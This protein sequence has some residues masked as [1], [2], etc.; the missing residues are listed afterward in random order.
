V[1]RRA[2]G[3]LLLL[4]AVLI[5]P[6]GGPPI[7]V[8]GPSPADDLTC[9]V[10]SPPAIPA[11]LATAATS[12]AGT[13]PGSFAVSTG[14]SATYA[15]P[16]VV[17]PGRLGLEPRLS[18]TY[19][20]AAG[21]GPLGV[22]FAL[23]GVSAITRC[24]S[25]LA[26]DG[27]I[28]AVEYDEQ[29]KLC[30]GNLRLVPARVTATTVE[31][32]TFP[33]TFSKIVADYSAG[34]SLGP[35]SFEV[36]AKDGHVFEYGAGPNSR[37]MATGGVVAAWWL[38][39]EQDRRGNAV[40]YTYENDADPDDA[41]TIEIVPSR[42]DYTRHDPTPASR[43]VVLEYAGTVRGLTTSTLYSGGLTFIRSKLLQAIRM[44][45]EP[46]GSVV[47]SYVFAYAPGASTGRNL[48]QSVEECAGDSGP[49]K[50]ATR[51]SWSSRA[52]ALK[53]LVTPVMVPAAQ[54]DVKQLPGRYGSWVL[55]DV[56]G[57][58]LDD[59]VMGI[60]NATNPGLDDWSVALNTGGGFAPP[61]IW[62]T[63]PHPV[64]QGTG[65]TCGDDTCEDAWKLTPVDLDQDGL[66]DIFLDTANPEAS[67]WPHYRWLRALPDHRFELMDTDIA[68]PDGTDFS[69]DDAAVVPNK[70]Y[71][72]RFTR[73]GDVNGDG[74][75][76]LI[77]CVNPTWVGEGSSRTGG[78]PQW[79]VNLWVP[80]VPGTGGPGFDPTP[81][82]LPG[83]EELDCSAGLKNV[84]V[85]DIDGA[86]GSE[87]VISQNDG[88][89]GALRFQ[90]GGWTKIEPN[91]PVQPSWRTIH[92]LDVNGD[93]LSDAVYTGMGTVCGPWNGSWCSP[94]SPYTIDG[95]PD[96]VPFQ[97][98]NN[99]KT[100]SSPAGMLFSAPG[101]A[102]TSPLD[103]Y[104]DSA[105]ALDANGDG[106]MDLMMPVHGICGD[107]TDAACW[108]IMQSSATVQGNFGPNPPTPAIKDASYA[109]I[110]ETH[111]PFVADDGG[112][113]PWFQPQI[114]DV[115]GDGRHD[116]VMPNATGD[117]TFVIYQNTGPQDLLTAVTD[118]MSPLDPGD[119]GFVATISIEYGS[120]VD[121]TITLG[122]AQGSVARAN[123][124]YVSRYDSANG[125]DYPR[126]CVV[127]PQ[128]VVS[129]YH[130][131][132]GNNQ[133]R[134]FSLLY[135]DA[136]YHRL[137]R[138]DLGF[139]ERVVVD[140]DTGG[141]SAQIFDNVT[142]DPVLSTFP[143]AGHVVRSWSWA[144]AATPQ[145]T[146]TQIE[147]TYGLT[148]LQEVPADAGTYFI[149]SVLAQETRE[150]GVFQASPSTSLLQYV[151]ATEVNAALVLGHAH[152]TVSNY[153]NY[154][155]VL[156]HSSYAEG[157]DLHNTET[158][159]VSNDPVSW[160]IGLV[161]SDETCSTALGI[162][163]CRST[164]LEYNGYGEVTGKQIGDPAD[165]GTQLS[166][167]YL[168]DAWGNVWWT[169][170]DDAFGHHRSACVVHDAEGIFPV[171]SQNALAHTTF[172]AYDPGLGVMTA[173]VDPNGLATQW[174]HD[175]LGR[176]T[177]EIRPDGGMTAIGIAREKNGGPQGT[178]WNLHVV[179]I[180][181]GGP[182]SI[183]ALDS[184]GRTVH[185]SANA[186]GTYSCGASLCAP[187]LMLEQ[188]T[189]YDHLGRLVRVTL[190]WMQGDSLEG[191]YAHTYAYDNTGRLT[192]HTEPWGRVTTY[193]YSDN[194]T[195]V[196]DWLGQ[197]SA[198][199]DALGRT[200]NTLDKMG[201][202]TEITYGPFSLSA[203]VTRFGN[204]TTTTD[205]D[206]YGRVT[207]EN[208][209]DRGNTLTTYDGF[210][211][212][213]TMDDALLRHYAFTYD[214]LGRLTQ[215]D[216][217]DA[218]GTHTTVRAYD[219]AEHGIGKIAQVTSP[220][221]HVDG[222]TYTPL[223]QPWQHTLAF[224]DT[225]ER[226][227]SAID[228]D[229]LGRVH[230]ITYPSP[231]GIAPLA[232]VRQYDDAGN[233]TAVQ[234]DTTGTVFWQL[235]QLD[236][237]GRPAVE[238]FGNR[239]TTRRGYA[240]STGL[241]E[242]IYTD[243]PLGKGR[244]AL[245]DLASSHDLGLRMKT[246]TDNL[247]AAL[248]GQPTETF[249]HDALDRLT[250][251]SFAAPL[252]LP[253]RVIQPP[254]VTAVSYQ[255]NGNIDTKDG[256]T[257]Y[258]YD[259]NHPHAVTADSGGDAF[260]YDSAGN[261]ITRPGVASITYTPFNLPDTYTLADDA[262]F[263]TLVYNG[264]QHRIRKTTSSLETEY[265]DDLFE[266]VT[267]DVE[268]WHRLYVAAGSA[269]VV[270]TRAQ[271]APDQV[272]YLH[273]DALG[274]VDVISN[275]NGELVEKRSYDPFGA[276]R[277]PAWGQPPAATYTSAVSPIGFTGQEGDDELGLVN[278][279]GRIY[280]PKVGRFLT[281]DPLVSH[282]GY[283]QS[284]NPYSYVLNSP[285]NFT[286]PSG[287]V[288][289]D[290]VEAP[291]VYTPAKG[292]SGIIPVT[293]IREDKSTAV[294]KATDA[295]RD[296]TPAGSPGGTPPTQGTPG[297][298]TS[299][300]GGGGDGEEKKIALGVG[301]GVFNHVRNIFAPNVVDYLKAAS[302]LT[303]WEN[304]VAGA[305]N[306][307]VLG[308][309][310]GA[311]NTVNPLY[312]FGIGVDSVQ[313]KAAAGD[314]VGATAEGVQLGLG[315]ATVI[316][317]GVVGAEASAGPRGPPQVSMF[318]AVGPAEFD[319]IMGTG[320]FRAAPGGASLAGKQFGLT[321]GEVLKFT[322][323]Y[324]DAAA[325]VRVDVPQS[326]FAQFDFS[327]S[328][329]SFIFKSGV[330]TV[331][332][333]AQ[334]TLL[335]GTLTAVEHVF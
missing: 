14:G 252:V 199:V 183:A 280:D 20:S 205:R 272:A 262:D 217:T 73:L 240:P 101:S 235:E 141:G 179:T 134:S 215:R 242:E 193:A 98:L 11:P 225:G 103:W 60:E 132:D 318:R 22:G 90:N 23:Q 273:T 72:N 135:R 157:V 62:A 81:I 271:G 56:N 287:F 48:L 83:T 326:S 228:Y 149:L 145:T 1:R 274:S 333:G 108:M 286:D 50:P 120:L 43:A 121:K 277:N 34:S 40:D 6:G 260:T 144:P 204:E 251:A 166:L 324:R 65:G 203:T 59:L 297:P 87:I 291:G 255:P 66:T 162:T 51:F 174:V 236:G 264:D 247:Q 93:G 163:Q 210:R 288:G 54:R 80:E 126:S 69:R 2:L 118:G 168:R 143:F 133:P 97:S 36:F 68:Q 322:D 282:P 327:R 220:S 307:G 160:L 139:G 267:S 315:L 127:G 45:L 246:R 173:A 74:V 293:E 329:D 313:R 9:S 207:H 152:T 314:T 306:D 191:S 258:S 148:T 75:A 275:S 294:Q 278:M 177:E 63:L 189:Q 147:L 202:S 169:T 211:E 284:W 158:R 283:S 159:V 237:G 52:G 78:S 44:E 296:D 171:L 47:R 105:I 125:C 230:R 259:P 223:S 85:V 330:V 13:I 263:V 244:R 319:D 268:T 86:P 151:E 218:A 254:C 46:A 198:Q 323:H 94:P 131:S 100:F 335:N 137:G 256:A 150:E 279:R 250:C 57:D 200:I 41:H 8:G 312:H 208:D 119:P 111:I 192:K 301:L 239:V 295:A 212:P 316:V 146:P 187:S 88:R 140:A 61:A 334:Q 136:R 29:D 156:A 317:G 172:T 7:L 27:L 190:P 332:P 77:Q 115:D 310:A 26:Q 39:T 309:V 19:D 76:D 305:R 289:P 290:P 92:F 221:G 161:Q 95:Y 213:L 35:Q 155:N 269:T 300:D 10:E 167:A 17:P 109:S 196:T 142:W 180:E 311:V 15:L 206:A 16:L 181:A 130:Q 285:L 124:T 302:G 114:T 241:V 195:T 266:Q 175:G 219:T 194:V 82:P 233:V 33:D 38:S 32:R 42:I 28:R 270:I 249:T 281:T 106:R 53:E 176:I 30:M 232:V 216:D 71:S 25:N 331:Q 3:V 37:A 292:D 226:F 182:W 96:D 321:L 265:V 55:A 84:Y 234:D 253:G 170:A 201:G 243:Y 188:D 70:P 49:C 107:G 303:L 24:P 21:D 304:G 112:I 178:W 222:Y 238:G 31:Y 154:G 227:T 185:T 91:I 248:S 18:V 320:Q 197:T 138:G 116:V 123:Q 5:A 209:P 67:S 122:L 261:Q 214:A 229:T 308:A 245:Q 231:S 110:V 99:G 102:T 298:S 257:P 299:G 79:T 128:Q 325:I 117:G 184:L 328:I 224:A 165:P 276:R 64:T 186:A 113:Y 129:A 104:G 4:L 164:A 89:Y 58:G 12:P 153:D